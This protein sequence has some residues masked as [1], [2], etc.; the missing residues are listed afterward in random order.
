MF[1][2][3]LRVHVH[4][5]AC[6]CVGVHQCVIET[7]EYFCIVF[8]T[9]TQEILLEEA[10]DIGTNTL[11]RHNDILQSIANIFSGLL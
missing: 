3:C 7:K 11:L 1:T 5:R 9:L 6:V 2:S 8:F 10:A 4:V